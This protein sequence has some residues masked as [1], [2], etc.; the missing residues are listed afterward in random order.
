MRRLW[1][2]GCLTIA[3]ALFAVPMDG[4]AAC[5]ESVREVK[6]ADGS[7]RLKAY[8]CSLSDAGEP[9][10]QVEFDRLSEAAAGS[11][12]EGSQYQDLQRIHGKWTVLHNAVFHQAK[13]LFDT[14]GVRSVAADCFVFRASSA[15]TGGSY[16]SKLDENNPCNEKRVLWYLSF[17]DR[18]DMT[19]K[20]YP[21]SWKPK[22]ANGAWPPGWNFFYT[23]CEAP[24]PASCAF[25]WRPVRM[26][27]LRNYAKDVASS[28]LKLGAPLNTEDRFSDMNES[29]K[30]DHRYFALVD[31]IARGQLP[32]D[33]L[34]LV[35][36]DPF[37][38]GCGSEG[39]E[40]HIRQLLL[41]AAFLRNI[42]ARMIEIDGLTQGNDQSELLRPYAEGQSP[43]DVQSV[44]VGPIALAP[45]ESVA[46]PLR[47]NFVPAE[48]L[49]KTF[50]DVA[51]ANKT[52]QKIRNWPSEFFAPNSEC[53]GKATVRRGSFGPPTAPSPRIY[54]Y[55]PAVTL[56]GVSISGTPVEFERSLSNFFLI[57][58]G[59]G[60]GSCPSVYAYDTD[61][62]EWVRH[63]KIIDNASAPEK[64]TTQRVSLVGLVTRFKIS[65]EELEL[66]FVHRVRLELTLADGRVVTLMPRH[67]LRPE[68]RDH[69]DKIAY[70]AEREYDFDLPGEVDRAS[71]V[72]STLAVTGYYLR[73]SDAA[74]IA[75][76]SG[77]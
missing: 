14:Y 16:A 62:S 35:D 38:C 33:F 15:E 77:R 46:I 57:A 67:R 69:Y 61:D 24:S 54:S 75:E 11:L 41:H 53:G 23:K 1:S 25:L 45:G 63:G 34:T 43:A 72:K 10:L 9:V 42:S 31:H 50:R 28:A 47:I 66:T 18:E 26:E 48:S 27:D 32:E 65:E 13:S 64:E 59:S 20:G 49:K 30:E 21:N 17:P 12:V 40:I 55:G 36:G 29:H 52:Y 74:S 19:T 22:L 71:V 3:F 56:K 76:E 60:Y 44:A 70:G 73:Y 5:L 51:S 4:R 39:D 8:N 37:S 7:A 68:G 6:F 2:V 58:A